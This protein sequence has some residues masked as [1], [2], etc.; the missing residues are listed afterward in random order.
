MKKQKKQST[1]CEELQILNQN[2][3]QQIPS[4]TRCQITKIYD[5]NNHVDILCAD[6]ELKYVETISNNLQIGNTGILIF[7]NGSYD[8]YIVLTK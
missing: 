2:M 4:P 8:E 7:L 6:G 5:D 3:I 1:L